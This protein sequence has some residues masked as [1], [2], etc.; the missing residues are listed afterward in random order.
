M[1]AGTLWATFFF[2]SSLGEGIYLDYNATTPVDPRVARAMLPWLEKEFGNPSSSHLW[3]ARARQRLEEARRDTA[4]LLGCKPSEVIFTSGGTESNNLALRGASLAVRP[5]GGHI[6]ASAVE[7][8][9]ALEVLEALKE[10]AD[11]DFTLVPVDSSCR[12]DP[13]DFARA[14]REET[15]LV[16]IM[17]AN[18][19]VGTLQPV[20]EIARLAR[21][22]GILVHTD[23]SQAAGKILFD[24]NDLGADLLTIAGHKLYGPKG[25]GALYVR[26]GVRVRPLLRGAG[27]ERGLR[28][29]TEPV[30][31]AAGLGRAARIAREELEAGEGERLAALRDRV[32]EEVLRRIPGAGVHAGE[33]PRLPNTSSVFI[34]GVLGPEVVALAGTELALS[35]GAACH[36]DTREISHVLRAMGVPEEAGLGTIRISVGR[37]TREE[38][39]DPAL[40]ILAR[41]VE[42]ARR[43]EGRV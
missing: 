34:P 22:R 6:V 11:Y 38:E 9:A 12:T 32:E 26:E 10:E 14:F 40:E 13:E 2:M 4:F 3:G 30:M 35:A 33:A 20:A 23:A 15:V 21:A 16:T 8:P 25:V 7:H 1:P 29:G 5:R 19:E 37:F 17:L 18:N 27:Q 28:P 36:Q 31:L 42:E 43:G 24:V 39:I 41:A